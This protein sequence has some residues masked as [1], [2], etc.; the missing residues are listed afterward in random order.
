[1]NT[2]T[3]SR[4]MA[5]VGEARRETTGDTG[6]STQA[7]LE[8]QAALVEDVTVGE[9]TEPKPKEPATETAACALAAV[10]ATMSAVPPGHADANAIADTAFD[11]LRQQNLRDSLGR[12]AK[13]VEDGDDAYRRTLDEALG[14]MLRRRVI[15]LRVLAA[16][17]WALHP[18]VN[19]WLRT[20]RGRETLAE[21]L[22][23]VDLP[24]A[25]ASIAARTKDWLD[26]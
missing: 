1:M 2:S 15:V 23:T 3:V 13:A 19:Q 24:A 9:S 17:P 8:Y 11:V 10:L 25:I 26:Q 21:H 12:I 22:D 5:I 14:P 20:K 4:A 16:L 7:L 6:L 18:V